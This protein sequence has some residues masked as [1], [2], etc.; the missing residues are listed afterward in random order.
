MKKLEISCETLNTKQIL[1]FLF[2]LRYGEKNHPFTVA[3]F[4]GRC[5]EWELSRQVLDAV[6][7]ASLDYSLGTFSDE[8]SCNKEPQIIPKVSNP[9]SIYQVKCVPSLLFLFL[10]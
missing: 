9:R 7:R 2:L 4:K 5:E 3:S 1:Y 8:E 6:R 10:F